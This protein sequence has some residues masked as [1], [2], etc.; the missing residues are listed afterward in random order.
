MRILCPI[1][2]EVVVQFLGVDALEDL[3]LLNDN[4]LATRGKVMSMEAR[5]E[6]LGRCIEHI[7]EIPKGFP[8]RSSTFSEVV[9]GL[10]AIMCQ[11]LGYEHDVVVYQVLLGLMSDI[12][13]PKRVAATKFNFFQFAAKSIDIQLFN[14]STLRSFR[15][16]AYLVRLIICQKISYMESL[17]LRKK[18]KFFS[19]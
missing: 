16:Q 18:D 8:I 10:V 6:L 14:F 9:R 2:I 3:R 15:Y 4:V 17:R 1:T 5:N 19:Y 11:V 13:P 12:S 7:V